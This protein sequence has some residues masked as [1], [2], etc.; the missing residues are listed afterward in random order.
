MSFM[1]SRAQLGNDHPGWSNHAV[2]LSSGAQA[3]QGESDMIVSRQPA[4][5]EWSRK[6]KAGSIWLARRCSQ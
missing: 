4:V 5:G 6:F 3:A 1:V 2:C